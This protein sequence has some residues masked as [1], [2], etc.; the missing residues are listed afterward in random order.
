MPNIILELL[1]IEKPILS[2]PMGGAVGPDFVA[3]VLLRSFSKPLL[4]AINKL[5]NI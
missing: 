5:K 3:A 4:S 1:N 2:A